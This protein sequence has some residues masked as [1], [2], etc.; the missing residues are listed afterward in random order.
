MTHVACP[1]CRLRFALAAAGSV[2]ACPGCGRPPQPGL[3]A[4]SVVGFRVFVPEGL[5][6]EPPEAE[7]VSIMLIDPPPVR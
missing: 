4:E 2:L 1:N 3:D 5:H 7:V 6:E